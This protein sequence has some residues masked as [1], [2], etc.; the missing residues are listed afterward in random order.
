MEES[1]A[2]SSIPAGSTRRSSHTLQ[3]AKAEPAHGAFLLWLGFIETPL[4]IGLDEF[5]NV[6]TSWVDYLT[7]SIGNNSPRSDPARAQAATI[8]AVL[9]SAAA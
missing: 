1:W 9:S 3:R 6:L 2:A 7:P 8:L 5:T 4:I